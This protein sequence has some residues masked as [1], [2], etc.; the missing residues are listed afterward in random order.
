MVGMVSAVCWK[1]I[2]SVI[3][4]F[5]GKLLLASFWARVVFDPDHSIHIIIYIEQNLDLVSGKHTVHAK[6]VKI[7]FCE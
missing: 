4:S 1:S 6:R 3:Y 2:K 5:L 7:N